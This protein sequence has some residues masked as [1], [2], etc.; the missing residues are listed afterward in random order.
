MRDSKAL[1]L[2]YLTKSHL[3][4][5]RI[6]DQG[7]DP[8]M[9]A[10]PM[11]WGICRTNVRRHLQSGDQLFFVA[12]LEHRAPEERYF[13]TARFSVSELIGHDEA[14]HRFAGRPNVMLNQ[15]PQGACLE[16]RVVAYARRHVDDLHSWDEYRMDERRRRL[17]DVRDNGGMLRTA[18]TEQVWTI[19]GQQYVHAHSDHHKDW[20]DRLRADYVVADPARSEVLRHPVPYSALAPNLR[21][22]PEPMQLRS[23]GWHRH[24]ARRVW[25]EDI[26][27]LNSVIQ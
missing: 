1:L 27:Y 19:E 12:A 7:N 5:E 9:R 13:L 6:Y 16:D 26:V 23:R 20:T 18:V 8:E 21:Y 2:V 10:A 22:L 14:L 24:P 3:A 15:L 11:T 17:A 4:G 25:D